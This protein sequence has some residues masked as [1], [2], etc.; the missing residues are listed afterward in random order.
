MMIKFKMKNKNK[1]FYCR[2]ELKRK[3]NSIKGPKNQDDEDQIKK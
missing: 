2:V 1:V 3:I